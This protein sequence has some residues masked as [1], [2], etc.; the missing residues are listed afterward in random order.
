MPGKVCTLPQ[1][2]PETEQH[3][4][5][6]LLIAQWLRRCLPDAEVTVEAFLPET[7]QR[8][9]LLAEVRMPGGEARRIAVE[10]QCASLTAHELRRRHRLYREAGIQDIWLLGGSRLRIGQTA[11]SSPVGADAAQ[12][13]RESHL[14]T[15]EELERTLL[16]EGAPLLFL[17]AVGEVL[18]AGVLARF[19]PA[20]AAPLPRIQ[21]RLS[22]QRLLE[23]EFPWH[24]LE[25]Q[26][27]ENSG[28][29][30][31]GAQAAAELSQPIENM[32]AE[33]LWLWLEQRYRVTPA[34][35][36]PFFGA[37]VPGQQTICCE[38]RL[39]QAALYYRFVHGQ[40]G[41][42]WWLPAV[43][44]WARAFLPLAQPLPLPRLRTALRAVQELYS[45][46][47]FLTLPVGNSRSNAR[48][49]ADLDT[50]PVPPSREEAQRIAR[51][52]R[53]LDR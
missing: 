24:L 18:D 12:P 38:A 14:L 49:A 23:L 6:K 41:E 50:L 19:R 42:R 8:A 4:A 45:A 9:D 37:F 1:T 26:S 44:T 7:M 40:I 31:A 30:A 5:G 34:A 52:R 28:V 43:E 47:G 33:Q 3:R 36:S 48:V 13:N 2:E 51:Y 46:A 32:T 21:G 17:D 15:T 20:E 27:R 16:S 25:W 22:A 35:L 10:Y 11:K 53:T 39:W 29:P